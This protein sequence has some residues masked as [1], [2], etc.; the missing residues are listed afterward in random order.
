MDHFL[1]KQTLKL[2]QYS[3]QGSRVSM[4]KFLL[5]KE[6]DPDSFEL[7]DLGFPWYV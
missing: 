7:D 4:T 6:Q 1:S 5:Q 2:Q 3:M